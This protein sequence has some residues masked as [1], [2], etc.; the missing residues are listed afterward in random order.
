MHNSLIWVMDDRSFLIAS[1]FFSFASGNCT[2]TRKA[3]FTFSGFYIR[4]LAYY[5]DIIHNVVLWSSFRKIF[6]M[7]VPD[8]VLQFQANIAIPGAW[9]KFLIWISRL[10]HWKTIWWRDFDD[11]NKK[12]QFKDLWILI[13]NIWNRISEII[14]ADTITKVTFWIW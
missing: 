11:K 3:F 13:I 7:C 2:S 6:P 10:K 5:T 8:S 14:A 12:K 1:R 9:G 4:M